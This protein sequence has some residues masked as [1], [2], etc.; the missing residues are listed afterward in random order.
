MSFSSDR[1]GLTKQGAYFT[2][3]LPN[4][5][6]AGAPKSGTSSVHQWIADHPDAC[7]AREKETYFFVDPGTHMYRAEAHINAGFESW[8][9]QFDMAAC[10]KASIITESTPSYIYSNTALSNIPFLASNPKVLFI[11]REPSSQIYSMYNYFRNNWNWIPAS[12]T[13]GDFLACVRDSSHDFGGNEL[14]QNA[15][16][17]AG[18]VTFLRQWR[19]RLGPERMRV[20]NFD[21]LRSDHVSFMTSIASWL[22]LD[23]DFYRDY[24]FP[25]ENQTYTPKRRWLQHINIAVRGTLPKGPIYRALRSAYRRANTHS[26]KPAASA[27][28]LV[29][30]DQLREEFV[31]LNKA[32]DDEFGIRFSSA[33]QRI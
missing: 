9:H 30:L 16:V 25:T 4:F 2:F 32:L 22:D 10:S 20:L 18:Y 12:M 1:I 29:L 15:L 31:E 33:P 6:I 23:P 24:T 27:E 17:N 7:G 19:D 28:D 5:F 3:P 13:F 21:D 14:A 8:R 26:A 11:I